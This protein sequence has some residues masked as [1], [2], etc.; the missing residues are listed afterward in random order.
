MPPKTP[1]RS[2]FLVAAAGTPISSP[3]EMNAK[4]PARTEKIHTPSGKTHC[5]KQNK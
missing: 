2:S 1:V 3:P 4:R 5:F